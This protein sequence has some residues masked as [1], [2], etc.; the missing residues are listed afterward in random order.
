MKGSKFSRGQGFP[1]PVNSNS[2]T[3]QLCRN[4]V[5]KFP[6]LP[7]RDI[8]DSIHFTHYP[9]MC[10]PRIG[11]ILGRPLVQLYR[12]HAVNYNTWQ[13]LH[14]QHIRHAVHAATSSLRHVLQRT[15]HSIHGLYMSIIQETCWARGSAVAS[16]CSERSYIKRH[17]VWNNRNIAFYITSL[18]ADRYSR[19]RKL[20]KFT[21]SF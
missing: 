2:V 4:Y 3:H 19:T 12:P 14:E 18:F 7:A 11:Y 21:V 5:R 15:F 6:D 1:T 20:H 10:R 8:G 9:S 13:T 16:M 17:V